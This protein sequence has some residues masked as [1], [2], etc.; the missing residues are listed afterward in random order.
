MKPILWALLSGACFGAG[1]VIS[2]M[3]DPDVVLAFLTLDAS[4]NPALIVVMGSAMVV[5]SLGFA[6]AHR[7]GAPFADP[8]FHEPTA[9]SLDARLLLGAATFGVGW[10]LSGYCPGPAIVGAASIDVRALIFFAAYLVGIAA[11][12][13]LLS[14]A[15]PGVTPGISVSG[16]GSTGDG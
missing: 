6:F 2:G 9:S 5:A 14:N 16:G 8:E 15:Q 3:T 4:W 7:R 1:L 12:E 10:G 13:W 11:Y